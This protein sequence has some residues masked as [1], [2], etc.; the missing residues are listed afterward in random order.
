MVA[1]SLSKKRLI[2]PNSVNLDERTKLIFPTG[3]ACQGCDCKDFLSLLFSIQ[4]NCFL[5]PEIC[6]LGFPVPKEF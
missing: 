1:F 2:F 3:D 5:G 6:L 4:L